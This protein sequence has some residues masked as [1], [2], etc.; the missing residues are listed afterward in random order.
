[1][2]EV[3]TLFSR[4]ST[5]E[6]DYH[7]GNTPKSLG[8][9]AIPGRNNNGAITVRNDVYH[10]TLVTPHHGLELRTCDLARLPQ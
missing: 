3:G 2:P 1:M 10:E 5:C 9:G 6:F 7:P 8:F 4:P